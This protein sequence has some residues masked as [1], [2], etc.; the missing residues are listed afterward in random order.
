MMGVPYTHHLASTIINKKASVYLLHIPN[1]PT[2]PMGYFK[3]KKSQT[4]HHFI[5]E[6][7]SKPIVFFFFFNLLVT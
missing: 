4:L 2:L 5:H 1:H 3:A 6:Y 7:I